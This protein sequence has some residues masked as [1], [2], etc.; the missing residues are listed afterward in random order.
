MPLDLYLAYVAACLLITLVPGPTVTLIVANSLRHGA[1]AGLLNVAGTSA[2]GPPTA[3]QNAA[4]A[5]AP[6]IAAVRAN[7]FAPDAAV[8]NPPTTSASRSRRNRPVAATCSARRARTPKR[9]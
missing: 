9:A 3:G 6:G 7:G 5:I 1:R 2:A 4:D 8:V